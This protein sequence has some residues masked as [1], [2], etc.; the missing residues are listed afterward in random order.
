MCN[1]DRLFLYIQLYCGENHRIPKLTYQGFIHAPFQNDSYVE[2]KVSTYYNH[3]LL[4][5]N[6]LLDALI[7][8]E[9]HLCK[10]DIVQLEK[11]RLRKIIDWYPSQGDR[12]SS[13]SEEKGLS[14]LLIEFRYIQGN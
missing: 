10:L 1:R 3:F 7:D 14:A 13:E 12:F 6:F 2:P 8:I 4:L 11:P 9:I 5:L